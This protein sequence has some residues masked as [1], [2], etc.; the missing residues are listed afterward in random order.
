M[1]RRGDGANYGTRVY[2][3]FI[4]GHEAMH[5]RLLPGRAR[6]DLVADLCW[7]SGRSAR[8]LVST[9]AISD[10]SAVLIAG[11]TLAFDWWGFIVLWLVPVYVFMYLGDLFRAL[12]EHAHPESDAAADEHRL[13]T[14]VSTRVERLLFAP[15]N[16]NF[17]GAHHLWPSIPYYNPAYRRSRDAGASAGPG[18]RATRQLRRPPGALVQGPAAA[19]LRVEPAGD[20]AAGVNAEAAAQVGGLRPSCSRELHP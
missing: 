7:S 18:D 6:N 8:S 14:F 2:A 3:L 19:G 20:E 15:M 11:L 10:G 16:I 5:R 9:S 4:I 12:L 1:G 13:T 17:H